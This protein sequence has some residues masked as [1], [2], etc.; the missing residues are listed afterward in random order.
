MKKRPFPSGLKNK[1]GFFSWFCLL[2]WARCMRAF[3]ILAPALQYSVDRNYDAVFCIFAD[4]RLHTDFDLRTSALVTTSHFFYLC[5]PMRVFTDLHQLPHF[6]KT[7]ITIGSFDGV[8]LGHRRILEQVRSLAHACGGESV[9][10]TFDPHPRTVLRPDDPDFKLLTSTAEK[11][12]P[13][14]IF[15]YR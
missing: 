7:V 4:F 9:V 8:H 3:C 1:A 10:I 12:Y 11:N 15:G 5:A 6:Q 14:G 2:Q 13:P